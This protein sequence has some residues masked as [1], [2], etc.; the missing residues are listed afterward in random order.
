VANVF[1]D[2]PLP[3]GDGTGA[4]VDASSLGRIKTVTIQGTFRDSRGQGP[5]ISI[6]YSTDGSKYMQAVTFTAPGKKKIEVA[7][8]WL[9]TRVQGTKAGIPNNANVDVG[10]ADDG[11]QAVSLPATAGSGVGAAVDVSALGT[12]NTIVCSGDFS[13]SV[14][15]EISEDN[16]DWAQ[17]LTFTK[18]G[19]KS[20]EFVAQYMRVRRSGVSNQNPGTATVGVAAI[21]DYTTGGGPVTYTNPLILQTGTAIV[22]APVPYASAAIGHGALPYPYPAPGGAAYVEVAPNANSFASGWVRAG[23]PG[24]DAAV[25]AIGY[26]SFATGFADAG[27]YP[28]PAPPVN[29]GIAARGKGDVAFG[30]AVQGWPPKSSYIHTRDGGPW[31]RGGNLAF[32]RT[33]GGDIYASGWGGSFAGGYAEE[34]GQVNA[35]TQG[36]MAFGNAGSY[37]LIEAGGFGAFASGWTGG[38]SPGP[39]GSIEADGTGSR[40]FGV[41]IGTGLIRAAQSGAFACGAARGT[42]SIEAN[43]QGSHAQ[44][45]AYY[46]YIDAGGPGATAFGWAAQGGAIYALAYGAFARGVVNSY[47][48][49]NDGRIVAG[50]RGCFASGVANGGPLYDGGIYAGTAITGRASLVHGRTYQ[51]VI[52]SDSEASM[53]G[54]AT[55]RRDANQSMI[56]ATNPGYGN[57]VWGH[58]DYGGEL[59]AQGASGAHVFGS[60]KYGGII[61]ATGDGAQAGGYAALGGYADAFNSGTMARGFVA[62]DAAILAGGFGD[63]GVASGYAREEGVIWARQNGAHAL[64]YAAWVDPVY[65]NPA[66]LGA[67]GSGSIA[68]GFAGYGG[69]INCQRRGG[70]AMGM[71]WLEGM[72]SAGIPGYGN[73][74]R[75]HAEDRNSQVTANADGAFASG[76]ARQG[77]SIFATGEGS[78]ALGKARGWLVGQVATKSGGDGCFAGG[79]GEECEISSAGEGCF[80]FGHARYDGDGG[81][82]IHARGQGCFAL[83]YLNNTPDNA[84]ARIY[85]NGKG[86]FALGRAYNSA[87]GGALYSSVYSNGY[88][89]FAQGFADDVG[90][91]L[92]SGSGAHAGGFVSSRGLTSGVEVPA[93]IE[94]TGNG[95]FAHGY[96]IRI[97]AAGYLSHIRASSTGAWAGG[98]SYA[99]GYAGV[100][101]VQAAGIGAMA[102]GYAYGDGE[103]YAR[104]TG[105]H[106]FGFAS[107][108][109]RVDSIAGA[110]G[111][112]AAGWA[113]D[114]SSIRTRGIGAVSMG[115]A[116]NGGTIYTLGVGG[117]GAGHA[118]GGGIFA[119]GAG[120]VAMGRANAGYG[121]YSAG[122]GSVALG[123]AGGADVRAQAANAFQFGPGANY[124]S[125]TVQIGSAGLRLKQTVGAPGVLQNG[126]IWVGAGGYVY[127]RSNGVTKTI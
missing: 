121:V 58:V 114:G 14:I 125:Y 115:A 32:G 98:F 84:N 118:N 19:G 64:G 5:S 92:A 94:S 74:A 35:P 11:A 68:L 56:R 96:A 106:V 65:S 46:G 102:H 50:N 10:A 1:V 91:V 78:H 47:L 2:L 61:R 90:E 76:H 97:P 27:Y 87:Y 88:G 52:R 104:A 86:A 53:V 29:V 15:I 45:R 41:T 36:S 124:T 75:G 3:A 24:Q 13:G 26:G 42:G 69:D 18:T 55:F 21:N 28:S 70:I 44:G 22:N 51:G 113:S 33:Y 85:A 83:G 7:A 111:S 77:G 39:A 43:G 54:G 127:I 59:Y 40:A 109:S 93:S 103:V 31:S 71:A 110:A 126:D 17:C 80:A 25:R 38:V 122:L 100:T 95:A 117:I 6:E 116:D 9:R 119:S 72:I 107:Y 120:S 48:G 112:F 66:Y 105:S 60:A 12:F 20:K 108:D 49:A 89:S 57:M 37:G 16:I 4:P 82:R 23:Y 73:M 34:G 81:A 101:R 30:C 123:F 79:Y 99:G 63:G 8:M 62:D 67:R